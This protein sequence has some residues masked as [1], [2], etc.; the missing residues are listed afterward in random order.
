MDY[1]Q[2]YQQYSG[3]TDPFGRREDEEDIVGNA[4]PVTQTIKTDPITG[5]QTMTIKGSPYDLSA[6]NPL[7]PTVAQPVAP[8]TAGGFLGGYEDMAPAVPARPQMAAPQMAAPQMAA[9]QMPA[10]DNR[11]IVPLEQPAPGGYDP[12]QMAQVL[13][14]AGLN[15]APPKPLATMAQA[16]TS[17]ANPPVIPQQ[18]QPTGAGGFLGG[19]EDMAAAPVAPSAMAPAAPPVSQQPQG[20]TYGRGDGSAASVNNPSGL[21]A[22]RDANGQF[23]WRSYA[24]PQE[25]VADTQGLVGTYLSSQG[26][27]RGVAPTP[28]NFVGMWTTGVPQN[29]AK[30]QGGRYAAGVRQE[31]ANAGVQLN[32]DG[33]IP[34]T[35]EANNAITR[36]I[37]TYESGAKNAQAFMPFV[38]NAGAVPQERAVAGVGREMGMGEPGYGG[39]GEMPAVPSKAPGVD[40]VIG[41]QGN[42]EQLAAYIG[43]PSNPKEAR[44][45]AS[46]ILKS[47][48]KEDEM[49]REGQRMVTDAIKN[50]DWKTLERLMKPTPRQKREDE[51]GITIGG[52]AKAF[53]YSAIGFQSGAQDVVDKMGV[54]AKWAT[55]TIGEDEVNAK[56]RKDGSAIE[57]EY[58]TGPRAGQ[59][60]DSD[61]LKSIS[62]GGIGGKTTKPDAG[63]IY[64]KRDANGNVVAKGRLITEY[65]NNKANTYIDLGGNKRAAFNQAWSPES[66]STSAA[67][68]EQGAAIKLRYA[69]PMAYTEAGAKAAGEHNTMYGTNIG[70]ASQTPGAPLVDQN[71]GKIVTPDANGNISVTQ[72]GVPGA[73]VPGTGASRPPAVVAG[74]VKSNQEYSDKLSNDRSTASAQQSTITRLQSSI[75]KNPEFWGIDTQSPTWRA[76]VDVNSTNADR[77]AAL[78]TLFRNLNINPEKRAEFDQTMNDYRNLQVN[79]ITGS[80]LS[81]SQT[82][83]EREGERVIG[84]IGSIGDKP[85]AAR[86]TLEFANAKIEYAKEKARA[87][88]ETRRKNPSIDRLEFETTFDETRGEKI[89]ADANE[90]MQKILDDARKK[91]SGATSTGTTAERPLTPQELARQ[92]IERRRK[93]KQ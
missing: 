54:G 46:L 75:D 77:G 48:Y 41:M 6:A 8:T 2:L 64:E 53:L 58:T 22:R 23:V 19:Y 15:Y 36:A 68:A 79:A 78:N 40:Q 92:E 5:E 42:I 73:G 87:W 52:I 70:Y 85:A 37:I 3:F 14:Q 35:P 51:D 28:E 7:T 62:G 67:K 43:N 17:D 13:Q 66:I 65:K 32:P 83:T 81:A 93:E 24:T 60:L 26:P 76:F 29:G 71:T 56:F 50:G 80:G 63:Q 9:P 16:G 86:A 45:A 91:Q 88:V 20:Y 61:E 10:V 31:L 44:D 82:N 74:M 49:T 90:R 55:T 57:G 30:E 27:M 11:N 47:R 12:E 38:G 89:F 59:A 84:T 18:P 33:T 1:N 72:S 39:A 21:G 4:R 25:G 69:G 34:N